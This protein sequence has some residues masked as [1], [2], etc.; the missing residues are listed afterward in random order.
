NRAK[1]LVQ[2]W[3]GSLFLILVCMGIPAQSQSQLQYTHNKSDQV[4]R[5]DVRVDPS[6]HALGIQIP[7][8]SYPGRAGSSV[9]ITLFYSSKQWRIELDDIYPPPGSGAPRAQYF[10]RF[11]EHSTAGWTTSAGVP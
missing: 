10:A 4:L 11:A 9:P 7:L 2:L 8:A 1:H 5:S 6:T 3:V